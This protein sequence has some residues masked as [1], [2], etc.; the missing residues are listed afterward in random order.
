VGKKLKWIIRAAGGDEGKNWKITQ[1]ER[2]TFL[3]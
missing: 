1:L 2:E 3:N